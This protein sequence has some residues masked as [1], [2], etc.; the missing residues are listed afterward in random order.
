MLR[1]EVLSNTKPV[2]E[3]C[4]RIDE[5]RSKLLKT[6]AAYEVVYRTANRSQRERER[7]I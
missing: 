6:A 2:L 4:V 7:E 3:S 1:D 5:R